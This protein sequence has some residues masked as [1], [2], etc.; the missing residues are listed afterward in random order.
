MA[1]VRSIIRAIALISVGIPFALLLVYF[2][3]AEFDWGVSAS[4]TVVAVVV[5]I[6]FGVLEHTLE[7]SEQPND[8]TGKSA[9]D[10]INDIFGPETSVKGYEDTQ[11]FAEKVQKEASEAVNSVDRI[12][13]NMHYVNKV[14]DNLSDP[15][16]RHR[17]LLIKPIQSDNGKT[18]DS[19]GFE[20]VY[21]SNIDTNPSIEQFLE[22]F[23][24]IKKVMRENRWKNTEV[25]LY[26]TTP[27]FRATII[28][29]NRAGFLILPSMYEGTRA[30]KFWTEDPN[31]V[32]TLQSIYEDIWNDPR[33]TPF[34]EWY[35][36]GGKLHDLEV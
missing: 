3:Q 7:P 1:Q 9:D 32:D 30:A 6:L 23:E 12:H 35:D 20:S 27:W 8:D 16:V 13:F 28:D 33:T 36:D 5:A 19:T 26:E 34:E 14:E 29:E 21:E 24:F 22:R 15:F 31:I 25:R 11:E 4:A 18:G 17:I 2:L 10:L